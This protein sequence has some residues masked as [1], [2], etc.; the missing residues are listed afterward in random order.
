MANQA[1][2]LLM[3]SWIP[4][5]GS[6]KIELQFLDGDD[7]ILACAE[8]KFTIVWG[9]HLETTLESLNPLQSGS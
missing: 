7:S 8:I 1:V 2:E 9:K 5:Q 4:V 6:Y 3:H